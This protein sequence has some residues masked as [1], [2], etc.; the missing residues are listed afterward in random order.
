MAL[1]SGASNT[2]VPV[3]P[4]DPTSIIEDDTE[5]SESVDIALL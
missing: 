5:A 3:E 2:T 1:S 4:R